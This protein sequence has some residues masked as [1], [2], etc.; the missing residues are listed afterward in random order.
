MSTMLRTCQRCMQTFT[1]ATNSE[2]ACVH[3]PE[4]WSGEDS[5]RWTAPGDRPPEGSSTVHFFYTCCGAEA[6][7]ARGCC[8]AR[9]VGFDEELDVMGKTH[10]SVARP[11]SP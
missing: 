2:T 1:D 8:V 10:Q 6:R 3:H 7:D 11:D 9:H 4:S 5:Q